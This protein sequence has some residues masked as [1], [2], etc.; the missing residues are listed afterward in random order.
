[1]SV[2]EL[3][4]AVGFV[5]LIASRLRCVCFS[6]EGRYLCL[7]QHWDV[8]RWGFHSAKVLTYLFGRYWWK[9]F[10]SYILANNILIVLD[11]QFCQ[12]PWWSADKFI[13]WDLLCCY[14]RAIC[15]W[16]C[17]TVLRME[18]CL[19]IILTE[20]PFDVRFWMCSLTLGR[21]RLHVI[22]VT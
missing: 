15:W 8:L 11:Q 19:L 21:H 9:F 14:L 12:F 22:G 13:C 6:S 18:E 3:Y 7:E 4:I 1:M 16:K 2:S 10:L 20:G 5:C 17:W